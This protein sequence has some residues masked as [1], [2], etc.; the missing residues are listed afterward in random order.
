MCYTVS[1]SAVIC[2]ISSDITQVFL[3]LTVRLNKA[4]LSRMRPWQKDEATIKAKAGCLRLRP[5][6]RSKVE[7]Q[8]LTMTS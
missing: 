7:L 8:K 6:M 2:T 3:L 1:I 4:K 5:K